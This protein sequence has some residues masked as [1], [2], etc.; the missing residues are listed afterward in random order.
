[1]ILGGIHVVKHNLNP[2]QPSYP[3]MYQSFAM[4]SQA[5]LHAAE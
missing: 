3:I 1:M 4:E 2:C 5:K